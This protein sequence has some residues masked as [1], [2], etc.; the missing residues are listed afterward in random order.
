MQSCIAKAFPGRGGILFQCTE[1]I[2]CCRVYFF[3][4]VC[5]RC[6]CST[7]RYIA[8][9]RAGPCKAV[10]GRPDSNSPSRLKAVELSQPESAARAPSESTLRRLSPSMM[11]AK[12]SMPLVPSSSSRGHQTSGQ[13]FL[14]R[15]PS[16]EPSSVQPV[17][18]LHQ[19]SSQD[20][21]VVS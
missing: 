9:L 7:R 20:H 15:G 6:M 18:T 19:L 17:M 14:G 5:I 12:T 11:F 1:L 3:A 16:G 21:F 2:G 13:G 4:P 8:L 10:V